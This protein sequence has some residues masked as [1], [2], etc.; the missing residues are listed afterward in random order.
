MAGQNFVAL[1]VDKQAGSVSL[2]E[3]RERDVLATSRL[4]WAAFL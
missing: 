3:T 1:G 2:T 4:T